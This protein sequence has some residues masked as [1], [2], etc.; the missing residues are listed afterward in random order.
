MRQGGMRRFNKK[1]MGYLK[2]TQNP[3]NISTQPLLALLGHNNRCLIAIQS[4][5]SLKM[6]FI[7]WWFLTLHP[8][9]HSIYPEWLVGITLVVIQGYKEIYFHMHMVAKCKKCM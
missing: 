4:A 7:L 9:V 2:G 1:T 8:E 5:V 6:S 3:L